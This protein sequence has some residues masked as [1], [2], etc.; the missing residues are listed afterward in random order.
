MKLIYEPDLILEQVSHLTNGTERRIDKGIV[1]NTGFIG[2]VQVF[3]GDFS[4]V[5]LYWDSLQEIGIL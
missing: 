5:H 3:A 2:I 1:F 4:L